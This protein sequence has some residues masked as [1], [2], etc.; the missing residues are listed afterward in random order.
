M[1][2]TAILLSAGQG[3]RLRPLSLIRPKP[4]FEVMNRTM[5]QWWAETFF[6]AGVKRLVIN[7]HCQ[8]P[9][10]LES[11]EQLASSYK[12]S[13]EILASPEEELLGTG[14]GIKNAA[15]LLGETDFLVVNADIFTD[16]ELVK[17]SLKHLANPGRLATLGLLDRKPVGNVS[18]GEGGRIIAFR[19]PQPV[20]GELGR[21][22][23]CGIMALSPA[24][25]D[26]IPQGFSDIITVYAQAL[27][28]GLDIY[29][30]TYD[31]AIWQDMGTID[32]YWELNQNLATGRTI[33]HSTA[34]VE[35]TLTG[36]NI[37]GAQ[38]IVEA[39]ATVENS[40][41][42]PGTV[43]ARQAAVKNAVVNGLVPADSIVSGGVFCDPDKT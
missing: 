43:I 25:F 15:P 20:D 28:Q 22:T 31:P 38:A 41:L 34:Q 5:L 11:I 16:F 37:I 9:L 21:Q 39:G 18:V 30:W 32:D 23:Y 6:S 4:L 13:L 29:G 26:L 27:A 10:M 14:G 7:A 19:Q 8:I 1:I 3:E 40:V 33:I 36:W 17:L 42:W 12:D 2:K 24:I 35:G